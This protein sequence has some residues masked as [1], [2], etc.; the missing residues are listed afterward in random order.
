MDG[1]RREVFTLLYEQHYDAVLRFARRR[2]D[3]DL[4]PDVAADTFLVAWRHMESRPAPTL[5]WLYATARNVLA[6]T[7][8]REARAAELPAR[9]AHEPRH[10]DTAPDPADAAGERQDVLR[11]LARLGPRDREV[12]YLVAWEE[13]DVRSAAEVLGCSSAA[14]AVRL[15]RARRRLERL[16]ADAANPPGAAP[17]PAVLTPGGQRR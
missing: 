14:F 6:N 12:L 4:A 11:L 5:P 15:H 13:L 2:I 8:R 9:A 17:A 7:G 3:A 16:L 1:S 10:R